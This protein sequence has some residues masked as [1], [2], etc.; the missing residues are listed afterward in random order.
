MPERKLSDLNPEFEPTALWFDCPVCTPTHS[1]A[2]A[3]V[4]PSPYNEGR[5]WQLVD[6]RPEHFTLAPSIDCTRGAS[7][8]TFHG[9][10]QDGKVVWT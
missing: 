7:R 1:I 9:H 6:A 3:W 2:I 5:L 4:A 10:V 8:C